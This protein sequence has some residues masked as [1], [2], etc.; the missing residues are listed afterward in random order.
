MTKI[1]NEKSID[2]SALFR[3]L[4]RELPLAKKLFFPGLIIIL[5]I[6]F[7]SSRLYISEATIAPVNVNDSNAVSSVLASQLGLSGNIE[8]DPM[9]IFQSEGLKKSMQTSKIQQS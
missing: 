5:S 2:L 7:F 6:Y 1:I 3:S 9:T 8:I 4:V